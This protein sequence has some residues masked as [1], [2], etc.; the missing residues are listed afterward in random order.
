MTKLQYQQRGVIIAQAFMDELE[1]IEKVAGVPGMG[2]LRRG[3]QAVKQKATQ[4]LRPEKLRPGLASGQHG[5]VQVLSG[6][7]GRALSPAELQQ[8]HQAAGTELA[9]LKKSTPLLK[10]FAPTQAGKMRRQAISEAKRRKAEDVSRVHLTA[11]AQEKQMLQ[12]AATGTEAQQAQAQR[13]LQQ[14][15]EAQ[16]GTLTQT[17]FLGKEPARQSIF[18]PQTRFGRAAMVGGGGMVLGGGAILGGQHLYRQQQQRR[19]AQPGYYQ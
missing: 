18:S 9:A 16:K 12:Q 19:Y 14:L 11:A 4:I 8:A 7:G 6:R 1:A 15:S 13:Y 17:G 2:L 3:G 5:P 10:R